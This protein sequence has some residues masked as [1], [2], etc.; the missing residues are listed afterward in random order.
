MAE[1][2]GQ[3]KFTNMLTQSLTGSAANVHTNAEVDIGLSLFDK[4]G[5]LIQRVEYH[6]GIGTVI[7]MT[8]TSDF[9][10]VG[11]GTNLQAT[12]I[13]P[14]V[15]SVIDNFVLR[16]HDS[17]TPTSSKYFELPF[18]RDFSNLKGG[19]ILIT[20]RPWILMIDSGGLANPA[21]CVF[22]FFFTVRSDIGSDSGGP[23]RRA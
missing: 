2:T 15:N 7:E 6:V 11:F 5:I 13:D 21:L 16:R 10:S 19:G 20:P 1:G 17:G 12:T 23:A 9:V 4:V 3:D 22:R 18:V 8:A 14:A